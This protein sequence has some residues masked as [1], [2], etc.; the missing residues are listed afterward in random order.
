MARTRTKTVLKDLTPIVQKI[1]TEKV[2]AR[3]DDQLLY[4]Y[5]LNTQGIS[6]NIPFWTLCSKIKNKELPS[7]ESIGRIRRKVQELHPNLAPSK[8]AKVSKV[9]QETEYREYARDLTNGYGGFNE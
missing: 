5:F 4:C 7:L 6:K 3:D 2:T 1:L 9:A 8:P